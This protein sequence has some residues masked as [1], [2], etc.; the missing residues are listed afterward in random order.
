MSRFREIATWKWFIIPAV[1]FLGWTADT[2]VKGL[3][4]DQK[5][6]SCMQYKYQ[7]TQSS[8]GWNAVTTRSRCAVR[9]GLGKIVLG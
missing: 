4:N 2:Y 6:D 5:F 7:I 9:F 1:A 3:V 8:S